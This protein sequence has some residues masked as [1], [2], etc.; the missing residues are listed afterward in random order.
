[1]RSIFT[2]AC[3][4]L[5]NSHLCLIKDYRLEWSCNKAFFNLNYFRTM[6]HISIIK[7]EKINI[8]MYSKKFT[9]ISIV[10]AQ[11]DL[12]LLSVKI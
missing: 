1:M 7:E 3:Q 10:D 11:P 5:R 8:I 2:P 9:R 4:R 12:S 6:R